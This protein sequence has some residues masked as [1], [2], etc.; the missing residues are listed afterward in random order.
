MSETRKKK[1]GVMIWIITGF[2]ILGLGGF[3][4]TGAFQTT[5]ASK[6]ATVGDQEVSAD[7]FI[8]GFRQDL[9][10]ASQQLGQNLTFDEARALGIDQN[11]LR[12]QITLAALTNESKRLRLSVGNRSVRNALLSNPAFQVVAGIFSEATYDLVLSQQNMTR[13]EY[14]NLLRSDETMQI[15]GSAISGGLASQDTAARVLMD[16][17]G[18]S[19]SLSWL[20]L[21]ES[22]LATPTETP[23]EIDIQAYYDTNPEVFTTPETRKI[24]Y[25]LLTPEIVAS[26]VNIPDAEI[27]AYYESQ[28]TLF[29]T[30][31]QRI[32]DQLVFPTEEEAIVARAKI[33]SGEASFQDIADQYQ[34]SLHETQ[35][36]AIR[37]TQL[38]EAAA[39]LIFG[40]DE[41]GLYGPVEDA[42]GSP[43]LYR[44]NATM[45][46]QSTPLEDVADDIRASLAGEQTGTLLLTKIGNIDDL[47][48]GGASLEELTDE[49]DMELFTIGFNS[50]SDE[51]ITTD[52]A[53]LAE[54]LAA[55][56]GDE[57]DLVELESGGILALRVDEIVPARLRT[58]EE[59]REQAISGATR[60]ATLRR[61]ESFAEELKTRIEAG[62]DLAATAASLGLEAGNSPSATRT[63]PPTG[64]PPIVGLEAFDQE[65]GIPVL[66]PDTEG[67]L[68]VVVDSITPFDPN[69]ADGK[70]F[71]AQAQAQMQQDIGDDLYAMYANGIVVR[72]DITINQG[73]VDQIIDSVTGGNGLNHL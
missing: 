35:L 9:Q 19:R 37:E 40:T 1:P 68:I 47:I 52:A 58:L 2:L 43:T 38:S 36:G 55:D 8:I 60:E 45:A 7:R 10:R 25:A 5:G 26:L 56:P 54:A 64:L 48:A 23:G 72:T 73:L 11:S 63:T 17:I 27:E 28:T 31:S 34:L 22:V 49:T 44:V 30:P 51:T 42:D 14:E 6:I 33:E 39:K 59:S 66:Y 71:L 53:F 3:G 69:S 15:I 18:E 12:R 13:P 24:T 21:D 70:A 4:L 46:A 61:I 57:R 50:L 65:A 29:N 41:P 32:M 20:A 67:T 16:F 62:A